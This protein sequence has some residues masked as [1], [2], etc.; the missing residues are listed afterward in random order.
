MKAVRFNAYGGIDV[1]QVIDVPVPEPGPDQLLVKVRAA[2]INPGEAKIR[3]GAL[4]DR[5]PA[6]F[7][8]GEGSDLA[9]T[10]EQLGEGVTGFAV[11]DAVIGFNH[12]RASHAEYVLVQ[13]EHATAKPETL[14]WAIAGGLYV[15]GATAWA[16]VKAVSL[17]K[18]DVVVVSAAAGGVGSLAVQLARRSGARV[19][20]L[21]SESNHDWLRL[22]DVI[23]IAYGDG[24][25]ARIRDAASGAPTAF[26]DTYGPPYV[27]LALELGIAPDTIDTIADFAAAA[28]HAVK[29][30][31]SMEGSTAAVLKELAE[32]LAAGELELP[33]AATYPLSE[34]RAAFAELEQGHT[35]GKIVLIP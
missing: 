26:V 25:A 9:G 6:T 12:E 20:G 3:A 34:V 15:A 8:S 24:V 16:A 19:I 10:V 1:L 7:P 35:R 14:A 27:E 33:V 11:G 18:G 13:A 5:F 2:G 28:T 22:H 17:S 31:G 32:L 21:A 4:H 30:E 29:S 23:P